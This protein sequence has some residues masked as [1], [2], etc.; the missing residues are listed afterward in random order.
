MLAHIRNST[1]AQNEEKCLMGLK[2]RQNYTKGFNNDFRRQN[3]SCYSTFSHPNV[4]QSNHNPSSDSADRRC[5]VCGE[6]G[7]LAIQ[8][9]QGKKESL[10]SQNPKPGAKASRQLNLLKCH[11]TCCSLIQTVRALTEVLVQYVLKIKVVNLAR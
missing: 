1:T 3:T 7:H 10:H 4:R 6:V 2:K 11:W 5:Y 8:C 9:K